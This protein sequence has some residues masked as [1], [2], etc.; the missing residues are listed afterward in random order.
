MH[1]WYDLMPQQPWKQASEEARREMTA[2]DREMQQ[3]IDELRRTK[4]GTGFDIAFVQRMIPH[5]SAGIID[6]SGLTPYDRSGTLPDR[7]HHTNQRP[8]KYG[9]RACI[10]F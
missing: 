2:M 1:G 6:T 9:T 5:H 4:A 3:R 7:S 10:E 8:A